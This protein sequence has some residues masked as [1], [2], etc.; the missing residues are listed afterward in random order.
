MS[1]LEFSVIVATHNRPRALD[2][3]LSGLAP[4]LA[5]VS[6]GELI[7]VDDGSEPAAA[8]NLA[9]FSVSGRLLRTAGLGRSAARNAA[10]RVAQGRILV[11]V[12]DDVT[13]IDG[14]IRAHLLAQ[15]RHP[16]ALVTGAIRLP[17]ETQEHPFGR[18]RQRLED[19][20]LVGTVPEQMPQNFCASGNMS[21]S[22]ERFVALD[23][24]DARLHSAEDQDL[25]L[26]HSAAGGRIVFLPQASAVHRDEALDIRSYCRR[27]E[28]GADATVDFC[29][30]HPG[31]PDNVQRE[32]VNGWTKWGREPALLSLRKTAKW[33]LGWAPFNKAL[34]LGA[35]FV[36]RVRPESR[37]LDLLYRGLLGI[38]LQ[39]GHRQGLRRLAAAIPPA[40]TP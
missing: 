36:E 26:R 4:A 32:R 22:L 33:L 21:L 40:N 12:D 28:W 15:A 14:F 3:T 11:F 18:F 8:P 25:A 5:K 38:H 20:G 17:P 10:A 23:G 37:W 24:F 35:A 7:V 34:L 31:F 29:H 16:F 30:K 2:L 27:V 39:R 9:Q 13:V 1:A 19:R 6:P